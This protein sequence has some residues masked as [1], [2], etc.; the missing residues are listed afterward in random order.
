MG[1]HWRWV[2]VASA[3][4]VIAA[5]PAA[6]RLLPVAGSTVSATTL[7][8]RITSSGSIPYSG[9]AQSDGG[10]DLPVSTGS[11][12]AI[13]DLLGGTNQLRV[14]WRGP[15]DWRVDTLALTGESDVH[16]SA[17]GVWSWNYEAGTARHTPAAPASSV[18]LPRDDDLLPGNLARRLLSE[19]AASTVTRLPSARIAGRSA[20]GLRVNLDDH[21]ST[22]RHIDVWALPGDG[23][24]LRVSVFAA[25][26]HP[27]VTTTLLDLDTGRPAAST[28][29]FR[30]VAGARVQAGP[31]EDLVAAIDR[32]GR[33]RPPGEVA[34]LA[35]RTDL[36]LGAVGVYGRGVIELVA[37]PLP[38]DLARQ[39]VPA[40]AGTSGAAT[41]PTGITVATGAVNLQL[42]APSRSGGRW[43]VVG[44]VP[45]ATLRSAVSELPPPGDFGPPR[46]RR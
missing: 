22:I 29:A 33:S 30:P 36:D 20:A 3:T 15:D 9:Y 1:R 43:L 8:A 24:P 2:V 31:G 10:L 17:T 45:A 5:L 37:V 13:G 41:D 40:I 4:A 35:R 26:A 11:L 34:G 28:I 42:S 39:V 16:Q 25:G 46:G 23:L 27:V 18:R 44:T 7:L 32:F 12:A 38:R 21:R 6:A 19:T 14:W